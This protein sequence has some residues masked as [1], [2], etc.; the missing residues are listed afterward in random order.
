LAIRLFG[1]AVR[2]IVA[3]SLTARSCTL[4]LHAA[5]LPPEALA[6]LRPKPGSRHGS[7]EQ[8]RKFCKIVGGV[9]SPL[10]ANVFLHYVLDLWVCQWRQRHARG[11]VIIVRYADDFVMG[12]QQRSDGQAMRRALEKRLAK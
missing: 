8:K 3:T 7:L 4:G 9:I 10:P 5:R 12:F 11:E 2:S 1:V 6:I